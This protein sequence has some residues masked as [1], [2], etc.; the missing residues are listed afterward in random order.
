MTWNSAHVNEV[1]YEEPDLQKAYQHFKDM[2]VFF[3]VQ[4]T[5]K[6][7]ITNFGPVQDAWNNY[8]KLRKQYGYDCRPSDQGSLQKDGS[9]GTIFT[10]ASQPS[11]D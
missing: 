4:V 3:W 10:R 11:F 5:R 2:E 6:Y 9:G 8:L 1:R 7:K